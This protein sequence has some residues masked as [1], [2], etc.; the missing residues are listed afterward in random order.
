MYGSDL[1]EKKSLHILI[2]ELSKI[3]GIKWI[4]VLYCY[5]EEIYDEL[6]DEIASNDK[7]VKYLDIPIQHISDNILKAYGKKN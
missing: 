1:Y 4:R 2:R 3:D 7:V 6:I 5:P